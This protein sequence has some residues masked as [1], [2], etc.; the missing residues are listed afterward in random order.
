MYQK[1]DRY[2]SS[3]SLAAFAVLFTACS[4]VTP[5]LDKL[6]SL[7]P[8]PGAA[9][10]RSTFVV[11]VSKLDD[12]AKDKELPVD[13]VRITLSADESKSQFEEFK[14]T[15]RTSLLLEGGIPKTSANSL[16]FEH[17]SDKKEIADVAQFEI[18]FE[19]KPSTDMK[20]WELVIEDKSADTEAGSRAR[21]R[22]TKVSFTFFENV[23]NITPEPSAEPSAEPSSAPS[24][25]P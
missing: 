14:K 23:K 4:P 18:G 8:L 15:G 19:T 9:T 20:A 21:E 5:S 25:H 10:E 22:L 2:K 17:S 6:S 11:T 13:A 12:N 24:A 3:L 1:L 16:A 7:R